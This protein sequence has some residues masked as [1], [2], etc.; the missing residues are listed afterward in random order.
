[1]P[2]TKPRITV[3]LPEHVGETFRRLAALQKRSAGAVCAELL[4]TAHEPICRVVA[5]LEAAADAPRQVRDGFRQAMDRAE[6]EAVGDA[7]KHLRQLDLLMGQ[8]AEFPPANAPEPALTPVPV[9]RGSGHPS[10]SPR[11]ARGPSSTPSKRAR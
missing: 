11:R 4:V 7:A 8:Y 6:A 3:T 1:M 10:T 5:I 9:T 2:T